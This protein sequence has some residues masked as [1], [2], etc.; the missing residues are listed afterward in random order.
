MMSEG[1]AEAE[2]DGL[3]SKFRMS[4]DII[5]GALVQQH[6]IV[7]IARPWNTYSNDGS[8]IDAAMHAMPR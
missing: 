1:Q 8:S 7:P 5:H 4:G 6:V 2:H 3:R